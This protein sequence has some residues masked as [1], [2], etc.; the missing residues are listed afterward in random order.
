[1]S[2][3]LQ[4]KTSNISLLETPVSGISKRAQKKPGC[5]RAFFNMYKKTILPVPVL[6]LQLPGI[7]QHCARPIHYY[8]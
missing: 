4:K 5:C 1:M 2:N 6:Y 3:E 7:Q 8:R